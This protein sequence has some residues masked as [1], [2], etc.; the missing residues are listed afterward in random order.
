MAAEPP[1]TWTQF[2]PPKAAFTDKDI[3]A[4]L[5]GKVYI[6]TGASSGI[7]AELT[8]I[9]FSKN[10]KVY[11]ACRS[12]EK[13]K[14]TIDNVT[15]AVPHS[16]GKLVF[17]HLDQADLSN[18]KKA[19][20]SFLAQES[21]LDVLFNNAGVMTGESKPPKKTVQGHEL[22]LGVNCVGPFL[23][24]K[25]LTPVL[26]A[27][28][29]QEQSGAVRVVWLSSYGLV[30]YAPNEKGIDMSN[31]DYHVP[32]TGMD[33]YG[34]SKA[35]DWLLS[36][37]YANRHKSDGIESVALNPG[38]LTTELARN[39]GCMIKLIASAVCYPPIHG[40]Y[41]LLFAAFSPMI[42]K[43]SFRCTVI[44]WG[45]LAPLRKD[46]PVAV[47]PK[48]QGGNGNAQEF[49]EWNEEQVKDYL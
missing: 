39:Q 36:A 24:T 32:K 40:V 21:R 34:I 48:E 9:L 31:L 7:G 38:N 11:L 16:K 28:A 33:R 47:K 13:A 19:A 18:V 15:A 17:I 42:S 37:E 43:Y 5:A 26:K 3:P 46:L 22:A 35:G 25:L 2:F 44:P 20:E 23:L 12:E 29:Q 14:K 41:T 45:R 27:T 4:D 49:W 6:I 8:R 30:A 10:A 1:S